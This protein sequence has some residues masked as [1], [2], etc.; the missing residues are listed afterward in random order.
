MRRL[1]VEHEKSPFLQTRDP[2]SSQFRLGFSGALRLRHQKQ[3][4]H[5]GALIIL[6]AL[7]AEC[8]WF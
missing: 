6:M 8:R 3:W 4:G 2:H 7:S 1:F 5:I